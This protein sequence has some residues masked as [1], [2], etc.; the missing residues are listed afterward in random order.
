MSSSHALPRRA[1]ATLLALLASAAACAPA[2]PI[3]AA[4]APAAAAPTAPVRVDALPVLDAARGT[5][6]GV[7]AMHDAIAAAE[8]VFVGERHGDPV[9]HAVELAILEA[10]AARGRRVVLSLEMFERDVQPALDAYLAGRTDEAAFLAATRPWSNYAGDYRPLVELARARGWPV[11]AANVPRPLA[12][13]VARGGLAALDTLPID[14]R[15]HA[16]AELRCPDD[17]YQ[18]KFAAAMG[19]TANHGGDG[20]AMLQRV[21][22]AQCVKDETMAES[23]AAALAP[24]VTVVHVTGSFHSDEWLGTA[25]RVRRRRP[26]VRGLVVAIAEPGEEEPARLGDWVVLPGR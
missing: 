6:G 3:A 25:E 13:A 11:V 9:A 12:A 18:A 17:R 7:G 2:A 4:P 1:R 14:R 15:R 23:V 16:A 10:L 8:V 21:Y 20:A 5:T 22:E 24:D 26:D 19:G